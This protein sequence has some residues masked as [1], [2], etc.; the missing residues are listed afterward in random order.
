MLG[1][2]DGATRLYLILGDPIAQVRSPAGLT[3]LMA[4]RGHN[5][6]VVPG[7]VAAEDFDALVA[8]AKRLRNLDGIV[9]T[10]PHKFAAAR[11]CDR[12]SGRA[13]LLGAVN[14]LRRE[15]DGRWA[16]EMLDGAGFVAAL[17][18]AGAEPA[19][20]RA[21]LVGAG[22]A[23][24]AIGAELLAAGVA[25]LAI[26]DTDPARRDALIARLRA[27]WPAVPVAAGGD[28]PAGFTLLANATPAGMR[29]GDPPP[30][31]LE[32]IAPGTA[33]GDVVT[34][35]AATPLVAAARAR[36]CPAATGTA[37]FEAQAA[38]LADFLMGAAR[39]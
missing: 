16:G 21:L 26:H 25:A 12:L 6:V 31:R 8:A 5:G 30:L 2:L 9:V 35:P 34:A 7:H 23:G 36:G 3:R 38:L 11:H 24:S 13:R 28:D 4:A 39:P 37:M 27:A 17:R 22:G 32:R 15:A 14:V 33:V 1:H 10:V 20:R 19:G 18:A 29:P